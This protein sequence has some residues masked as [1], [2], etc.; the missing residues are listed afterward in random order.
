MQR[1]LGEVARRVPRRWEFL[2]RSLWPL[3]VAGLAG[4]LI[5]WHVAS[6][7]YP[8]FLLPGPIAVIEAFINLSF[9]E[10]LLQ[11]FVVSMQALVIAMALVLPIG[12][13]LGLVMGGS[14][15]TASLV[16]PYLDALYVTP[17]VMLIPLFIIWFGIGLEARVAFIFMTAYFPIVINTMAGV[18]QIRGDLLEMARA[19]RASRRD[20]YLKIYLPGALPMMIAGIRLGFGRGITGMVA[21]EMFLAL[22][23]LG[24]MVVDLGNRLQTAGVLAMV[25]LVS[26]FGIVTTNLIHFME[27]KVAPWSGELHRGN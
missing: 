2:R 16:S 10:N 26:A 21:A 22:L 17:N 4:F 23:G 12:I 3:H 1:T 5:I 11:T 13:L 9:N 8:A 6:Q 14:P 20:I 27:R 15:R 18:R 25:L 24:Y 19:F 7:F